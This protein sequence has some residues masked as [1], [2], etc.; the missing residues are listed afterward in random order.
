MLRL[1]VVRRLVW[2]LA[3]LG[4]MRERIE[5]S[6]KRQMIVRAP[7]AGETEALVL[8][9]EE[10][11]GLVHVEEKAEGLVLVDETALKAQT[12]PDAGSAGR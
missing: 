1:V 8:V 5:E 10:T 7:D 9:E 3:D 11:E 12:W 4:I 6:F 2:R